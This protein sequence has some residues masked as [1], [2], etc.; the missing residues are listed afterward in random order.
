MKKSLKYVKIQGTLKAR[1]EFETAY[2]EYRPYESVTIVDN[3]GVEVHFTNLSFSKRMDEEVNF[4][5][6]MTFYILRINHKGKM[7]GVVYA[8]DIKGKK[9]YYPD[10]ALPAL[11]QLPL[12]VSKRF[13]ILIKVPV[14]AAIVILVGGGVLG[15][16]LDKLISTM[17]YLG[18]DLWT[19]PWIA[20]YVI[21]I[22]WTMSPLIF[23]NKHAG[24]SKM[25]NILQT[26]GFTASP[27]AAAKY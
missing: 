18:G 26:E 20:G 4:N 19:V 23:R 11:R 27:A 24:I 14:M 22:L 10:T 2:E 7:W 9:I 17:F 15:F 8:L 25:E 16:G 1:G 13:Q 21:A 5:D 3:E 12:R 6:E